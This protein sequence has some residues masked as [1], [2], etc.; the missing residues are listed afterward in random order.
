LR[1]ELKE[2]PDVNDLTGR[3]RQRL[4]AGLLRGPA[5][6]WWLR[7]KLRRLERHF[8][9]E[10]VQGSRKKPAGAAQAICPLRFPDYP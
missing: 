1:P 6:E 8:V 10:L 3:L 5:L 7:P 2:F 9:R 4:A